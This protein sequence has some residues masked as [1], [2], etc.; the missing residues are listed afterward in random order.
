MSPLSGDVCRGRKKSLDL[1]SVR[2]ALVGIWQTLWQAYTDYRKHSTRWSHRRHPRS[3]RSAVREMAR[4]CRRQLVNP[5]TSQSRH[6]LDTISTSARR[7]VVE[8]KLSKSSL[9]TVLTSAQFKTAR[10]SSPPPPLPLFF[11]LSQTV[12]VCINSQWALSL[13]IFVETGGSLHGDRR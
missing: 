8:Q 9:T 3:S 5:Q 2:E 10:R 4:L 13:S 12:G 1:Q 6:E 11:P 7:A